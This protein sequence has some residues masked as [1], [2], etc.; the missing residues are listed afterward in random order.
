M[1]SGLTQKMWWS[2]QYINGQVK[3]MISNNVCRGYAFIITVGMVALLSLSSIAVAVPEHFSEEFNS[4]NYDVWEE[5]TAGTVHEKMI[6]TENGKLKIGFYSHDFHPWQGY[7]GLK[8]KNKTVIIPRT[9][10]FTTE[11]DNTDNPISRF[12]EHASV[13]AL[14]TE[15]DTFPSSGGN[16]IASFQNALIFDKIL[17]AN[18]GVLD[19]VHYIKDGNMDTTLIYSNRSAHGTISET[20]WKVDFQNRNKIKIY[21]NNEIV[22]EDSKLDFPSKEAYLYTYMHSSAGQWRYVLFDYININK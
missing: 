10:E 16:A 18:R 4:I 8:T 5:F 6:T 3:K 15:A 12:P 21:R 7:V 19:E 1:V 20:K 9:I 11:L 14:S 13:V 22:Y 17:D 2:V